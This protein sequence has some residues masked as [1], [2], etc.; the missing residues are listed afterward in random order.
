M[1]E[2]RLKLSLLLTLMFVCIE[3]AAGVQAKSLALVS[4]A[5]HNFTDGLALALSWYALWIARKPANHTRTF[6]YHRVGI[7]TALFNAVTLLVI[8]ILIFHEGVLLLLHPQKAA[9][10]IMMVVAGVGLV[11]NTTIALALRR[12]AANNVNI[13]SAFVHM[14]GDALASL[15]VVLAGMLI[16]FTGWSLADPIVSLLIAAFIAYSSWGIVGETVNVLLEGTPRGLDLAALACDMREMPG[17]AGVHD[18]HVWTIAD[19]MH[20]LSCH[21]TVAEEDLPRAFQV[22]K[23]VKIMLSVRYAV[24]HATIETECGGCETEDLHC[25]MSALHASHEGP[26]NH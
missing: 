26:C 18:L 11:M 12:E 4:D 16:H 24:G 13:R 23:K 17:V 25:Q 6:G 10:T 3:L 9:G 21:L 8:A 2:N 7:L 19:G 1:S 15:G 20:A 22:V 5:G 14:A